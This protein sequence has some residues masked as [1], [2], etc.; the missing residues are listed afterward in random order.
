MKALRIHTLEQLAAVPDSA[1]NM[2][3]GRELRD[4]AQKF[5][6]ASTGDHAVV[7]KLEAENATL[8][9]DIEFL[10]TQFA[11]LANMQ[12]KRRAAR[13]KENLNAEE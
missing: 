7:T 9:T 6:S 4:K 2:M 1:L 8:R 12:P 5:L 13:D 3:G 11:E 10:K